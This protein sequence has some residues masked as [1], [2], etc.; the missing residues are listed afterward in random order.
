MMVMMMGGEDVHEDRYDSNV[1]GVYR[2]YKY[3]TDEVPNDPVRLFLLSILQSA[4]K[5]AGNR[6]RNQKFSSELA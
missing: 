4:K 3:D 5:H 1:S 6:D 2:K